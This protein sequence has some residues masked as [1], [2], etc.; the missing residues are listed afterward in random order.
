M[1]ISLALGPRAPLS[2]QTAWG[3]LTTNLAL[4]GIGSLMAGRKLGYA[5]AVLG[6]GG[7]ALS[8]LFGI[9]FMYWCVVNWSRLHSDQ[10]DPVT[11]LAE[12]GT[13]VLLPLVGV[14]IF[15]LGWL[16]ALGTSYMILKESETGPISRV[17]PRLG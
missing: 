17:P 10:V 6:F 1:K 5:Q 16:W 13:H 8:V 3:C 11:S 2:R 7:L 12:I 9:P 15:G 4:P 14:G